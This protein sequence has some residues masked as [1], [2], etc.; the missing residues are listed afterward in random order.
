[1]GQQNQPAAEKKFA[2]EAASAGKMGEVCPRAQAEASVE[3]F[4]TRIPA[5]AENRLEPLTRLL[6]HEERSRAARF[7]FAKD[8]Q[9]FVAAHALLRFCLMKAT[10]ARHFQ[11]KAGSFGKPALDPPFGDPPLYFNLSHTDALAGCVLA[12]GYPVG[13]DAEAIVPRSGMEEIAQWAFSED[14]RRL[15]SASHGDKRIE[16]FYRLWTMKEALVKGMGRGLGVPLR[17]ISFNLQPLSLVI[18]ARVGEDAACWRVRELV[19]DIDH[20]L[21]LAVKIPPASSLVVTSRAIT[22]DELITAGVASHG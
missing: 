3:V 5:L 16:V 8:R 20:R 15:L 11:L 13:I 2:I 7:I 22:I 14:E 9:V 6:S 1:M 18:G 12:R 10:G 21:A 19:F 4:H 17:D